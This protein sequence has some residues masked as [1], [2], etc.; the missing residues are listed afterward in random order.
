MEVLKIFHENYLYKG[1]MS[2]EDVHIN[3]EWHE[4]FQ[5]IFVC[6]DYVIL[7]QRSQFVADYK[8]LLDVTLGGHIKSNETMADGVREVKEELGIDLQFEDLKLLCVIPEILNNDGKLDKEF[9]NV[10]RYD[11]LIDKLNQISFEDEEVEALVKVHIN[12]F[13]ALC[14]GQK[15][16]VIGYHVFSNDKVSITIKDFLPYSV[17]YFKILSFKLSCE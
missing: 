14:W 3:E 16:L 8:G 6:D 5:C 13:N 9:I 1:K 7:Q 12:D 15:E 10:F 2:R 11:I 4:T 17:G